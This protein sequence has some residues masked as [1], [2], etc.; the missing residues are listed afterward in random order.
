VRQV[1]HHLIHY[2]V[3]TCFLINWM[4]MMESNWNHRCKFK[5]AQNKF[6][7]LKAQS[8]GSHRGKIEIIQCSRV[9]KDSWNQGTLVL[10]YQNWEFLNDWRIKCW[11]GCRRTRILPWH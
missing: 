1:L 3:K 10:T 8:S 5:N 6:N 9:P 2:P 7:D 4:G 11:Q